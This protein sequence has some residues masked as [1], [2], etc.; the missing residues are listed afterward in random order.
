MVADLDDFVGANFDVDFLG[1]ESRTEAA[2][3][4]TTCDKFAVEKK[5]IFSRADV[6]VIANAEEE[7]PG[8]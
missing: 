4:G 3:L 6:K 1:F 5:C 2:S 8:S 7:K